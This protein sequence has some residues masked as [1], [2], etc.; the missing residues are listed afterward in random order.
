[1]KCQTLIT[2]VLMFVT[3]PLSAGI[4]NTVFFDDKLQFDNFNLAD[5]KFLKG[6]EDFEEST[7]PP[8]AKQAFP[9][10]LQNGVPNVSFPNGISATNLI[11]QDNLD[12]GPGAST[13][14]PSGH[15][16]SLFATGPGFA[17]GNRV[18]VGEDMGILTQ[19]HVSIDL[20]FLPDDG[21]KTGV[22]FELSRYDGFAGAAG[23]IITV[24]DVNGGN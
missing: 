14:N 5:G 4:P 7:I 2:G 8:G 20:I 18:K 9:G 19:T 10:P 11:I 13:L 12:P 1:M 21:I 6:T 24:F 3:A 23:W 22:G 17:G 15:P 16:Q